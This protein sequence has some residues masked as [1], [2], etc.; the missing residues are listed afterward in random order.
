[1][2]R[3]DFVGGAY[4]A[5]SF[6]ADAQVCINF[7]AETNE[8]GAGKSAKML[9]GTPGKKL[10]ATLA[11]NSV[12]SCFEI[13]GRG[14]ACS[15]KTFY[16]VFIDKTFLNRGTIVQDANPP[17]LAAS[18]TQI[19]IASGG[20]GYCFSLIDGSFAEVANLLGV[21]WVG[22]ADGFFVAIV[23][24]AVGQPKIFV[25][26]PA[27][28]TFWDLTQ[29]SLVSVFPGNIVAAR[30]DHRELCI[31]GNRQAVCYY[32]SGDVF[33]F[34][35][36]PGAFMEIGAAASFGV[37]KLD[38]TY[39]FWGQDERGARMAWRVE[40]YRPVRISHHGI[41]E[42]TRQMPKISDAVSYSYQIGGHTFWVTRFPAGNKTLVYDVA[43]N[44]WHEWAH[45]ANGAYESHHSM[46]HMYVF[47]KHLV[48][49]W[50]TG[51][52]YELSPPVLVNGAWTFTDDDG[53]PIRRERRSPYVTD[54]SR[55][56]PCN[57]FELEAEAGLGNN[58]SGGVPSG[59]LQVTIAD[60]LGGFWNLSILDAGNL[61]ITKVL[62]GPASIII[63]QDSVT[64]NTAW[65]I[66][67]DSVTQRL[68]TTAVP[69]SAQ[70]PIDLPMGTTPGNLQ[71][72][73]SIAAGLLVTNPPLPVPREP[74]AVLSWSD[75]RAETWSNDRLMGLGKIGEYGKR[76]IERRL[77]R[78]WGTIGRVFRLVYTDSI[79]IRIVNAH[80]NAPP[81][82]GP[83][84]RL[85]DQL[86]KG[87]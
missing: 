47:E 9:L 67:V 44:L 17:S 74:V 63:L 6:A 38:N 2:A 7:F 69:F 75:N 1:M 56:V 37:S 50:A 77:G 76:M 24:Q 71:S 78:F 85:A 26:A 68:T 83:T 32:D 36:I 57:S 86:R 80:I 35:V 5:P 64:P 40:G 54:E 58:P 33:P 3:I 49:D 81:N 30:V 73:I 82:Y 28:G 13:N 55:W 25:S 84:P 51:N 20:H 42:L 4:Q 48:G 23:N 31:L 11:G 59:P 12:P 39:F 14:F 15:G 79:P 65:Q 72:A 41:E 70:Y 43:E 62:V 27:D 46:C 34:T 18:A 52:I 16:E 21:F 87:A 66:G 8:S 60:N 45:F 29:V 53:V 10:W 22:Y 61:Q 19:V